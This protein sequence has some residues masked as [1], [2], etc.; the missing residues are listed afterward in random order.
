MVEGGPIDVL[1]G[2]WLAELTMLI[3]SRAKAKD[4]NLGYARTFVAQMEQVMGQCLTRGIKVVA[5][6]GGLNPLSCANEV[7]AIAKKLGLSP[8]IAIVEG[9]NLLPNLDEL[10]ASADLID[11]GTQQ[12]ISGR[13]FMSANVYLGCWGIVEALNRGADIV[14][15]GRITDAA[16]VCGPAAWH[17][18]WSRTDY[19]ALAGAVVAGHVLECGTQATGGNYCFFQEIADLEY[20]GFPFA[21]I[22]QD[23]SAEI[24]KHP[25]TGGNVTRGTVTSQ[26]L[27]EIDSPTYLGPDVTSRFDTIV[28]RDLAKDRVLISGV[29]GEP[30]PQT[31]KVSMTSLLGYRS[32]LTIAL[33][34]LD[35]EAKAQLL[36][37]AFW[38]NCKL[39][40]QDFT[41]VTTKL[42]RTDKVDPKTN[43]EAV[44]TW[45]INVT[46]PSQS[47]TKL[48][49]STMND[50]ALSSIPGFFGITTSGCG[51]PYGKHSSASIP[52]HKIKQSVTIL[53]QHT[54]YV[55][56]DVPSADAQIVLPHHRLVNPPKGATKR[57][58]LGLLVGTRSGDKGGDANIGVFVRSA[59]AYAWLAS[60]LTIPR[61]RELLPEASSLTIDRFDLP[62]ILS[63]NFVIYGL[64]GD[65]ATASTR[66]DAQAKSL[67][68]W[69]RSRHVDV[70]IELLAT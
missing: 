30:P 64:L 31:L 37:R 38:R 67:G 59:L 18:G 47:K 46:D 57:V 35:I 29:K 50:L 39:S 10:R 7:A 25:T 53:G 55:S 23:G 70:P 49:A 52:R 36:E 65:G 14:I 26:L 6:A 15:G 16:V 61:L 69:L 13:E 43:E 60:Y 22:H 62:N 27:Y 20:P 48:L 28:L 9:D 17:Y 63:V 32:D 2:D 3:L 58:P 24:S 45:N 68:E 40:P 19:D 34:G 54:T 66:Q 5:N 42:D 41:N 33:T 56:S 51:Q 4:P 21:E 12:P 8:T 1:T 11:L 44:A